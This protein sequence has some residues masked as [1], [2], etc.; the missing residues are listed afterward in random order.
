MYVNLLVAKKFRGNMEGAEG[1][2]QGGGRQ[3]HP[4]KKKEE[5]TQLDVPRH[6][7]RGGQ[8]KHE[9]GRK[10]GRSKKTKCRNTKKD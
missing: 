10:L 5:W 4:E 8:T 7:G 3:S 1:H 2:L 9:N 6:E